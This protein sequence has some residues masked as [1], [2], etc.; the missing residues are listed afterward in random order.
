MW[1]MMA[2]H[3]RCMCGGPLDIPGASFM[4]QRASAPVHPSG[5]GRCLCKPLSGCRALKCRSPTSLDPGPT[6]CSSLR[7][8]F[9]PSSVIVAIT[10]DC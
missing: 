4:A 2:M 8:S 6:E 10:A 3:R 1:Q 7:V 5:A 9:L